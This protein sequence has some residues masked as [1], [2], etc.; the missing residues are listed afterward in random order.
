MIEFQAPAE[1]SGWLN[2]AVIFTGGSISS[3][4]RLVF[5]ATTVACAADASTPPHGTWPGTSTV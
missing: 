2:C 1:L 3:A 5:P 4:L